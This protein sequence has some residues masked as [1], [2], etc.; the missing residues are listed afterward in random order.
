MMKK[1]SKAANRAMAPEQQA[2]APGE[3][4]ARERNVET[5]NVAK[6]K[7]AGTAGFKKA[8]KAKIMDRKHYVEEVLRI[9][10]K[11]NPDS[12]TVLSKTQVGQ[13]LD[14]MQKVD[15]GKNPGEDVTMPK[16]SAAQ[17]KGSKTRKASDLGKM[18]IVGS[19][20]VTVVGDADQ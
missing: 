20:K 12:S 8:R 14:A 6:V 2:S 10:Q 15:I 9:Y 11:S 5:P 17:V 4:G 7:K 18:L 3:R 13:L 19:K 1:A 16:I